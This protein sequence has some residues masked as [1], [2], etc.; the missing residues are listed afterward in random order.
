MIQEP[1]PMLLGRV[2]LRA[3][4]AHAALEGRCH[5]PPSLHVGIPGADVRSLE[6]D[7]GEGL[8]LALRTEM[9]EAMTR[10]HLAQSVVPLVWLTRHPEGP[11][12]E[13]LAWAAAAGQAGAELGVRL[14]LVVVTR[15]SWRDPRSGV[16]RSWTR[17]R[18]P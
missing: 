15:R 2:L 17:L 10:A 12:L 13:D 1:V 18:Q 16:G 4:R 14:D 5:L 8:D 7:T 3:V 6:L 9:L 11:D